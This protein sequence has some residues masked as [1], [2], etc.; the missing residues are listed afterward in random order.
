[1]RRHA[2]LHAAIYASP[3]FGTGPRKQP[4]LF[5]W[6]LECTRPRTMLS[7]LQAQLPHLSKAERRVGEWILQHPQA[8]LDHDTRWLA[9]QNQVSQ[10]TLVRLA[11]SLGCTGFQDFRLKLAHELGQSRTSERVNVSSL[12]EAKTPKDLCEGLFDYSIQA[13]EK[14]R[15]GLQPEALEGAIALLDRAGRVCVFGYDNS[16][17]VAEESARRLMRLDLNVLACTDPYQQTIVAGRMRSGD[18]LLVIAHEGRSTP[19]LEAVGLVRGG[20]V[21]VLAMTTRGS[22]L[23]AAADLSLCIDVPDSSDALTPMVAQLAQLVVLD[24][25]AVGLAA[26]R[27][28]KLVSAVRSRSPRTRG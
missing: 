22:P 1:M 9:Q 15:D 11:H 16:V 13:L 2:C 5:S 18:L 23:Q 7:R 25:L 24:V 6:P 3:R 10:P 12:A 28:K 26:R 21:S 14:A 8:A 4:V 20:G 19:V 17:T 27:A